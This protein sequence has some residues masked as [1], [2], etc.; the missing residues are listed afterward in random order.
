MTWTAAVGSAC[1]VLL[2]AIIQGLALTRIS[3]NTYTFIGLV[4]TVVAAVL[5]GYATG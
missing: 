4:V 2:Q 5:F 1:R 3:P